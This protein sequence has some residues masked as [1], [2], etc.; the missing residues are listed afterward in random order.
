MVDPLPVPSAHLVG[1]EVGGLVTE[2]HQRHGVSTRFG[3]GVEVVEGRRGKL[4]VKLTDGGEL[5]AAV[6]VVGIGAE[7]ADAWLASSGLDVKNGVVCDEHCR[8][9]A[10]DVWAVG[11]VAR[12]FHPRHRAHVRIE[13]WT[14]AVEQAVCVAHNI[15]KPEDLR[16]YSPVEYVWSDQHDWK[17]QIVGVPGGAVRHELIGDPSGRFCALY[18]HDGEHVSGAVTVNWPKALL[19]CRRMGLG[20]VSMAVA[21]E[22]VK[23]LPAAPR[24]VVP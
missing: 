8:T 11:D 4:T 22:Q 17:I 5:S 12:W 7:P 9:S 14:N 6:V 23:A 1:E 20:E 2:L 3:A 16:S 10:P 15:A 18:T 13:H 21:V 24:A 19:T